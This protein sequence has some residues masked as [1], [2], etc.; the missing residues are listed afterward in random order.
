MASTSI[1]HTTLFMAGLR[2][3]NELYRKTPPKTTK[4][5][6]SPE[7]SQQIEMGDSVGVLIKWGRPKDYPDRI[8]N[9]FC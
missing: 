8:L 6:V 4:M 7:H 1:P 9:Y 2:V 5:P 3:Q